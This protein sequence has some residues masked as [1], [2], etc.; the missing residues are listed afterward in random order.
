MA[1][2]AEQLRAAV[3]Y[4]AGKGR[5]AGSCRTGC[6]AIT[7]ASG[8]GGVGKS[9]MVLNLALLLT[10]MRYRV[11]VVDADLGL[12]NLDILINA[13]P[14]STLA[15]VISGD[16]SIQEIII[17]GPLGLK[18]VPGGSGLYELANLDQA[19]RRYLLDQLKDLESEN[20]ILLID[21]G[22]GLSHT[23]ISFIAAADDLILLT[24]PEP[25]ALT[26]AY[27][28]MKV[29]VGQSLR[30]QLFVAVNF[31]RLIGQGERSFERL[32]KVAGCYLPY[33]E[34]R[35]LG[36]IQYDSAVSRAVQDFVPFV[37]SQPYSPAASAL[38]RIAWRLAP[39][40]NRPVSDE[41]AAGGFFNRLKK[42]L[43]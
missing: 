13:A 38:S 8:K 23:V 22:A 24:T 37:L 43:T 20:D 11:V 40:E 19:R 17:R 32:K 18:I 42:F 36:E 3:E 26:D 4:S 2:Q 41:R 33:L 9:N 1:D 29:I 28:L 39:G 7:V 12:S 34:L 30:R 6:R 5:V 31:V 35:Y 27:G 21:T 10:K 15:D 25:T 14:R 16:C